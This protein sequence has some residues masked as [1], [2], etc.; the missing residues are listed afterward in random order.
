MGGV[1]K[2]LQCSVKL[3]TQ[4]TALHCTV[5]TVYRAQG[6]GRPSARGDFTLASTLQSTTFTAL[7][8]IKVHKIAVLAHLQGTSLYLTTFTLHHSLLFFAACLL[9]DSL[10]SLRPCSQSTDHHL[11]S[12]CDQSLPLWQCEDQL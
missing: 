5:S 9:K 7:N 6:R 2:L 8:C 4:C 11:P 3:S 1:C 12:S 10:L